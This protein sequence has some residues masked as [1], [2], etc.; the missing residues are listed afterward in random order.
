MP[1]HRSLRPSLALLV[2]VL[3]LVVALGGTSYAAARINGGQ[4]AK[5]TI[6]GKALKNDTVTGQK[7]NEST[8]GQVPSAATAGTAGT[9]GTAA[10]TGP[11]GGDLAGTYPNPSVKANVIGATELGTV[12]DR[13]SGTA[14]VGPGAA[15]S[16]GVQCHAGEQV[17]GGGND[18]SIGTAPFV[19]SSGLQ[20]PNGWRVVV[21]NASAASVNLVVH[22]YCLAP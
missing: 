19:V 9:A 15:V 17:V 12:T 7:I 11:A 20:A 5:S 6:K 2:A 8:L 18:S 16:L 22:A 3:A 14:G 1:S 21:Y 13:S 10:P 4:I